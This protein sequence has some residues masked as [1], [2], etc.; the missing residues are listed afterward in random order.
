MP[1]KLRSKND[2]N[3]DNAG[4]MSKE[5]IKEILEKDRADRVQS[6]SNEIQGILKKYNCALDPICVLQG[7][8]VASDV[9]VVALDS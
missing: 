8:R 4:G 9:R 6:A 3:E 1:E 5:Q 7:G 2:V